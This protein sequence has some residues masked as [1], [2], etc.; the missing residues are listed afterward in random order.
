MKTIIKHGRS[1][2]TFVHECLC[3]CIFTYETIDIDHDKFMGETVK[4]PS[5][6]DL[7]NHEEEEDY[8]E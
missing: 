5:C 8:T 7:C 2:K 4:C 3:G 6:G 1:H